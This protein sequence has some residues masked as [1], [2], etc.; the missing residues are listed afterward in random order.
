MESSSLIKVVAAFVAGV[1]VALGSALIYT[2]VSDMGHAQP[3]TQTTVASSDPLPVQLPDAGQDSDQATPAPRPASADQSTSEPVQHVQKQK[4]ASVQTAHRQSAK[5]APRHDQPSHHVEIAQ[6]RPPAAYP[7]INSPAINSPAPETAVP[8]SAPAPAPKVNPQQ[9]PANPPELPQSFPVQPQSAPPPPVRQPHVV[10]LPAGT[11][12]VLRLG[13]TLS[14]DHNYTGDTFRA[15][16]E[17]PIIMDGFIIVDKG[18]KVLGRIANAQKAGRL[19]GGADLTL[20]VTE[21]NTTDGQ[22][23]RVDTTSYEKTAPASTGRDAAEIAGGAALGAIIGAAAGGGKGAAIGA[24]V[25][26]AAG[27]GTALA[28]HGK[29]AVLPIE[30]RLTFRLATPVTITEKLNY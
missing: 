15:T 29:P 16:L 21:L 24:G 5:P 17:T 30:T 18:S 10:T 1:V 3:V 9:Q 20:T 6:N 4:P 11:S 28:T 12:V 19:Q 14:T 25:G 22:R 13:E 26:G 27:T 7:P 8:A 2:R 23:V